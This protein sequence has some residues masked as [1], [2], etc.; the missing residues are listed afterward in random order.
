MAALTALGKNK[1]QQSSFPRVLSALYMVGIPDSVNVTPSK[2]SFRTSASSSPLMQ[3]QTQQ[4]KSPPTCPE[5]ESP[6]T[7]PPSLGFDQ[8][9]RQ[10]QAK[11][12][13]PGCSSCPGRVI[14]PGRLLSLFPFPVL[15]QASVGVC[16]RRLSLWGPC[17]ADLYFRGEDRAEGIWSPVLVWLQLE[18]LGRLQSGARE[19][20]SRDLAMRLSCSCLLLLFVKIPFFCLV[21]SQDDEDAPPFPRLGGGALPQ[22]NTLGC[23]A[24]C[25]CPSEETVE[26]GGL[27]L[28]VFP[29]NISKAV[30]HLSLQ[31]NR[32]R[33]L[34]YDELARLSSLKTLN[35]HNNHIISE[36]LPDE[37]FESLESLQYIYLAN[38]KLTVAPQILSSTVRI[39]DLA[40]NM[41]TEVYPLTFGQKANLRSVYLHN[42]QLTNTGLPYNAFNGSDAVSTMI[43][44]SNQLSYLPQNLPPALVRLHLQNNLI[45]RIPRGALSSHWKLRE[46]YL[47]NNNLSNEGIE[48]ST[49]SKLRGL[50]YLDLSN[51]N[52]TEIPA[53][54]PPGI[55]ILHLG[56]NR[57]SSLPQDSLSR[58]RSLQYL[59]LQSNRLTAAGVH[60]DAFLKLRNLHTLHLYNNRLERVPPGLP[61]RVRSLMLLHNQIS[62]VG[63]HDFASTYLLT[64]LNLS[65][66]RLYSA[67]IH[68]L[69]FRKLRRLESLDLA[70]NQLTLLPAGLP[71][72]LQ[73]LQLQKNQINSLSPELLANLTGLKELHLAQ[74]RLRIGSITPGTWQE[75][76]GLKL[77]DLSNNELSYIPPDLPESLEYLYLQHNRIAVIEAGAFHSIP[78]IRAIVLR[79]NRLLAASV[80]DKAFTALEQLEVVDT[81]GNPEPINIKM[82][83]GQRWLRSPTGP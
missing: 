59:L 77:L 60:P 5:P 31:N 67:R 18:I 43:L 75:L 20:C 71:P 81:T 15:R 21:G 28:H 83:R 38:N 64:E 34:P 66:N 51:N 16:G 25:T 54:F 82:P 7:P 78:D 35:L 4:T 45:S 6:P 24:N 61:R 29:S 9:R 46:L 8:T 56:K 27:D 70:G 39:V 58:V 48:P 68:R 47:Q 11:T 50:E 30:Q 3:P 32:L 42:N 41:L 36:G 63:L 44:S 73:V 37:A 22:K 80:S 53:N 10:Q 14:A 13:R 79:S 72:S 74:N 52:L 33:E 1:Q 2:H 55:L 26:C 69:A 40:A 49:F 57:I 12:Q 23:P 65:Y 76:Q 19:T 62:H 17:E